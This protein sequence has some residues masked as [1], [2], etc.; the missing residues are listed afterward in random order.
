MKKIIAILSIFSI[1][2]QVSYSQNFYYGYSSKIE[3]SPV[4]GL[5]IVRV[6]IEDTNGQRFY[7]L[8][9]DVLLKEQFDDKTFLIVAN[10]SSQIDKL[11]VFK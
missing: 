1:Y 9:K 6:F 2:T 7:S 5:Y 10:Q 11:Y 3:V 8:F 4:E